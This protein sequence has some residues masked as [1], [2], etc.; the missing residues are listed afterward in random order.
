MLVNGWFLF[1]ALHTTRGVIDGVKY[2]TD[3]LL[4]LRLI[5]RGLQK[6]LPETGNTTTAST[7]DSEET[8]V[9]QQ[10]AKL[11]DP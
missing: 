9:W 4:I 7:G 2:R 5:F 11:E 8:L 6:A 10:L 1:S 3:G